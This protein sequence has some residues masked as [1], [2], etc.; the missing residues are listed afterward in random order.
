[1][2][3]SVKVAHADAGR[4]FGFVFEQQN[5]IEH[6]Q[7]RRRFRLRPTEQNSGKE[8]QPS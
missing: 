4:G 7:D 1:V 5:A 2:A 6:G 8:Q 3:V